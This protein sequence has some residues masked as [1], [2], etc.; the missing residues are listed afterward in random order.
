MRLQELLEA[1]IRSWA[2]V[3]ADAERRGLKLTNRSHTKKPDYYLTVDDDVRDKAVERLVTELGHA[4]R[5][6][7]S[8]ASY[9]AVNLKNYAAAAASLEQ[10]LNNL[11]G[12]VEAQKGKHVEKAWNELQSLK[13]QS[14][15]YGRPGEYQLFV[16]RTEWMKTR[17]KDNWVWQYDAEGN[18]RKKVKEYKDAPVIPKISPTA[19]QRG[20]N[21]PTNAF[22]T[23]TL[24]KGPIVDD[25]QTYSSDWAK[26]IA[27][28]HPKWWSPYGFV[29][30]YSPSSVFLRLDD[31]RE[32][33]RVYDIFKRLRGELNPMDTDPKH[34]MTRDF[35]W[36]E[37]AKH[38]DGVT[39]SGYGRF[40]EYSWENFTS[41]WDVEST[42][43]LNT[44]VLTRVAKVPITPIDELRFDDDY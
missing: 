36:D 42:A 32:A 39:H 30:K 37:V 6:E 21:K 10:L 26:Y 23:S 40:D 35:P 2:D 11:D 9:V 7:F 12:W 20:H 43:W 15:K 29:Y 28:N 18:E 34:F 31:T 17:E 13:E 44:S 4:G 3:A 25:K 8:N 24:Y 14:L 19:D 5:Y 16:P 41:G 33:Q 22:W 27:R 38:F 1:A